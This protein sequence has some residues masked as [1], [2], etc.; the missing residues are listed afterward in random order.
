MELIQPGNIFEIP[1]YEDGTFLLAFQSLSRVRFVDD[2][3]NSENVTNV[4]T[5]GSGDE[6]SFLITFDDGSWVAL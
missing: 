3:G 6:I 4:T 2:D 1:T 5:I